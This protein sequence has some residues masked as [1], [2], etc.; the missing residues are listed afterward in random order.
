M[1]QSWASSEGAYDASQHE[2]DE[3]EVQ[4]PGRVSLKS[5]V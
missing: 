5:F 4:A 3:F 2:P 1:S